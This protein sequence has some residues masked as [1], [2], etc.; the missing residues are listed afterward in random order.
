MGSGRS[1]PSCPL[2]DA[3]V[4]LRFSRHTED[5]GFLFAVVDHLV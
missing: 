4:L 3:V 2:D 1:K 5:V